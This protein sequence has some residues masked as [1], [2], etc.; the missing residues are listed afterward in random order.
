M[1]W[2]MYTYI[3]T[4]S[5]R[6]SDTRTTRSGMP[7]APIAST[8]AHTHTHNST[9]TLMNIKH[10]KKPNASI[11]TP[12]S[13]I[14]G[15]LI[16]NNIHIDKHKLYTICQHIL[17]KLHIQHDSYPF[18]RDIEPRK[19]HIY[20]YYDICKHPLSFNDIQ[21][22]IDNMYYEDIYMF[23]CDIRRILENAWLYNE[24]TRTNNNNND[25]YH[26]ANNIWNIFIHE[27][28]LLKKTYNI[29]LDE[30]IN[31]MDARK[32]LQVLIHTYIY[33]YTYLSI[34]LSICPPI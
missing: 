1:I 7:I 34:Y 23:I 30:W 15:T 4:G 21:L 22:R 8:H 29:H 31:A 27:L 3:S 32:V 11:S 14:A 17:N 26:M 9:H 16:Y 13:D 18:K 33:V 12:D 6:R 24:H 10:K 25:I 19:L 28:Y 2:Y 20:D 5:S